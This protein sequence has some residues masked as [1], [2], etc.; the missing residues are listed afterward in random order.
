MTEEQNSPPTNERLGVLL[1]LF[2]TFS[3]SYYTRGA[4]TIAHSTYIDFLFFLFFSELITFFQ[5]PLLS[6]FLSY[7]RSTFVF[8]FYTVLLGA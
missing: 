2:F 5:V 4:P 7:A 1:V 3:L 8:S 6:F